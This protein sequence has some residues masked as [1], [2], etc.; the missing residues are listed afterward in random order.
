MTPFLEHYGNIW[1]FDQ[2]IMNRFREKCP[3]LGNGF[4]LRCESIQFHFFSLS[5]NHFDMKTEANIFWSKSKIL[6]DDSRHQHTHVHVFEQTYGST[7]THTEVWRFPQ[8][9]YHGWA[10]SLSTKSSNKHKRQGLKLVFLVCFCSGISQ[11]PVMWSVFYSRHRFAL[12]VPSRSGGQ[13][14]T[15]PRKEDHIRECPSPRVLIPSHISPYYHE[16]M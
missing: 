9:C 3:Y 5:Q 6:N 1:R 4:Q 11:A 16:T 15:I 14:L 12:E 10:T 7:Y 13:N 2:W 8:P